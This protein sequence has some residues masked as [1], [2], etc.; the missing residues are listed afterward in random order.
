MRELNGGGG[1]WKLTLQSPLEVGIP[2]ITQFWHYKLMKNIRWWPS[3]SYRIEGSLF[4]GAPEVKNYSNMATRL[5]LTDV[6][7][8]RARDNKLWIRDQNRAKHYGIS[9][10][11]CPCTQHRGVGSPFLLKNI[12][13]HLIRYGRSPDCRTYRRGPEDPD[14]SDDEWEADFE[15]KIAES[16]RRDAAAKIAAATHREV[17]RDSGVEVRRMVQH[18]HQ[19]VEQSTET[20]ERLNDIPIS[21]METVD[22]ITGIN[23]K[24]MDSGA[25]QPSG[26][27]EAEEPTDVVRRA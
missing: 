26:S 23:T 19:Q 9:R 17:N 1:L 21:A 12:F 6:R 8:I 13:R 2:I 24:Q 7:R 10:I 3:K 11:P 16:T 25:G 5:P 22:N 14:S 18:I 4:E 15:A 20:E 27:N